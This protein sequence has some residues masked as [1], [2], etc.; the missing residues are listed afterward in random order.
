[1]CIAT[2]QTT[3][4]MRG[5]AMREEFLGGERR[6]R[7]DGEVKLSIV[8]AVG[9]GGATVTRVTLQHEVARQQVYT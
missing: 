9:I 2:S 7:W 1:M 4:L 5:A 3:C 6:R 8:S